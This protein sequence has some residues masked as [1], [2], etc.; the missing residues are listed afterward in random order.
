MTKA[1]DK[2][3]LLF[4][5]SAHTVEQDSSLAQDRMAS[6]RNFRAIAN[7]ISGIPKSIEEDPGRLATALEVCIT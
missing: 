4:R 3:I 6:K 7:E 1:V 5:E 2:S